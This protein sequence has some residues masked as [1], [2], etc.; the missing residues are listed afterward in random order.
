MAPIDPDRR[1]ERGTRA[2]LG[3]RAPLAS[4]AVCGCLGLAAGCGSSGS[5]NST[6]QP[7]VHLPKLTAAQ[8]APKGASPIERE[9]YRQFPPPRPDPSVSKSANVIRA[10][11]EACRGKSPLEVKEEFYAVASSKLLPAQKQMIAEIGYWAKRSKRDEGFTA[12][13]LAADVYQATLPE[14]VNRFGYQGCVYSLAQRLK[15]ELARERKAG[16]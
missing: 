13:Q 7:N 5:D 15:H 12:G 11:E 6:T 14:A 3:F 1:K 9:I 8:R 2:Q 10:G 4:L 16:K